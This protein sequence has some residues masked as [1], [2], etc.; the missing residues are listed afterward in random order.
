MCQF[1]LSVHLTGA[2]RSGPSQRTES[3]V[4]SRPVARAGVVRFEHVDSRVLFPDSVGRCDLSID[5]PQRVQPPHAAQPRS[6]PIVARENEI[7]A[8][9]PDPRAPPVPLDVVR[10]RLLGR[11]SPRET[12]A[13]V[14]RLAENESSPPNSRYSPSSRSFATSCNMTGA[15][16]TLIRFLS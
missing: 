14:R 6:M 13:I 11:V 16:P 1:A 2:S 5:A 12:P 15:L 7:M 3:A 4:T 8:P 9:R 10:T